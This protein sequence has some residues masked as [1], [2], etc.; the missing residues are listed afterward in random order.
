[1]AS[2]YGAAVFVRWD[3][4]SVSIERAAKPPVL[5]ASVS[6]CGFVRLMLFDH[7]HEVAVAAASSS[8]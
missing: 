3:S 4:G 5:L 1:L 6:T 8:V 2:G 7:L